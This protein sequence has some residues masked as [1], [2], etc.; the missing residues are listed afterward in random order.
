MT[1]SK[2]L[3]EFLK[4]KIEERDPD[5]LKDFCSDTSLLK[6]RLLDSLAILQLAGWIEK[7]L[8]SVMDLS[9]IDIVEEWNTANSI[10]NFIERRNK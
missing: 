8:H 6:S 3:T 2:R 1:Q 4:E 7:E 5:A 9:S 10:L